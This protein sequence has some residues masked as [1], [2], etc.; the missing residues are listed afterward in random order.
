MGG[1]LSGLLTAVAIVATVASGGTLGIVAGAMI[2]ASYAA[3]K[4]WIGGSVGKFF[5]SSTGHYLTM[6][7]G[8][9]SAATS[10]M[11][12]SAAV[13][14]TSASA[15]TAS[16]NA[17]A[18]GATQAGVDAIGTQANTALAADQ[19]DTAMAASESGA[20][21][22]ATQASNSA[23]PLVSSS[24]AQTMAPGG[25][26]QVANTLDSD[27]GIANAA[28]G[29]TRSGITA[30]SSDPMNAQLTGVQSNAAPPVTGTPG[31]TNEADLA[32]TTAK[33]TTSLQQAPNAANSNVAVTSAQPGQDLSP[34]DTS[35]AVGQAKVNA[36]AGAR[37][38]ADIAAGGGGSGSGGFLS[39]ASDTLERHAGLA[40]VAGNALSGM[41]QGASQQKML[42]E[43]IA[44]NQW[45]NLQ[46]QD[47]TQVAKLNAA[48][49]QPINV[50]VGYLN[51]AA[52]VRNL[53]NGSTNQSTPLSGP[54]TP[55][56]PPPTVKPVGM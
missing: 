11:A 13:T 14:A 6:A 17:A 30:A 44:A 39:K 56:A 24:C 43:Q 55:A 22:G 31:G 36:A 18:E 37:N 42:Q 29:T 40:T 54:A 26:T 33:N 38:E 21:N 52:A 4:G 49:A 28:S 5:N 34:V 19:A 32:Q 51:R 9:A 50:P 45:G 23:A 2:A 41:A 20:I 35:Q 10:I 12:D 16:A 46:W 7:V 27:G 1:F 25:C 48:A 8:L 3:S 15:T 47:P 53:M